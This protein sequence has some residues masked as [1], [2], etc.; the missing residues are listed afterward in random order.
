M[1]MKSLVGVLF[2]AFMLV[3][4]YAGNRSLERISATNPIELRIKFSGSSWPLY[5]TS[6]RRELQK[7][8]DIRLVS[9]RD[10]EAVSYEAIFLLKEITN[11]LQSNVYA[12]SIVVV[13]PLGIDGLTNT[14]GPTVPVN[15][16]GN[17]EMLDTTEVLEDFKNS[18]EVKLQAVQFITEDNMDQNIKR[19]LAD[20]DTI[21]FEVARKQAELTAQL[22]KQDTSTNGIQAGPLPKK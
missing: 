10:Y 11:S 16:G 7:L 2:F 3:P 5:E 8:K 21:I 19:L 18:V 6:M 22:F 9:V 12:A 1:P 15:I 4:A 20:F 14:L 17:K 13:K